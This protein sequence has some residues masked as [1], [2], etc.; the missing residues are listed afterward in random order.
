LLVI[1]AN[2][3]PE[4]EEV[5]HPS[6]TRQRDLRV[7]RDLPQPSAPSLR[8]RL[9]HADRIRDTR[10]QQHPRR[11]LATATGTKSVRQVKMSPIPA[12]DPTMRVPADRLQRQEP[13][14]QR[15]LLLRV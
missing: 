6:R 1:D 14:R 10:N 9:P 5:E 2:R 4:P 11:E 13:T 15:L 3:T 8:P 7:H 12:P